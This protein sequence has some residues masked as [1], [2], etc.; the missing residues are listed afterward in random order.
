MFQRAIR[1]IRVVV[2]AVAASAPIA[3]AAEIELSVY[4]GWQTAPHS[5][6]EI[7]DAALAG[8]GVA[9]SFTAGWEGRSFEMPP[10]Y[11]LRATWWQNPTFGLG[12]DFVHAKVYAD[13]ATLAASGLQRLEFTDGLNIITVNAMRRWPDAFGNITPYVGAGL[14]VSFPHVEVTGPGQPETFGYQL[15]GPAATWIAGAS[16]PIND[17][18]SVFGEYKGT[19][20]INSANLD[21]GGTLETNIVTNALNVGVSFNF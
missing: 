3:A 21:S 16:I 15:T 4:G 8:A 7:D 13:D 5:N 10:Y 6:V 12:V 2:A 14:G 20:S 9:S 18:W 11:G 19:Y 1:S 17:S